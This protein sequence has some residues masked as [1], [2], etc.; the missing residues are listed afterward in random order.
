MA[1]RNRPAQERKPIHDELWAFMRGKTIAGLDT[2]GDDETG[3]LDFTFTD[4]SRLELYALADQLGWVLLT[5]EEARADDDAAAQ[6][7]QG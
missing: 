2:W 4:G 1:R 5:P 3:G 7:V 6:E